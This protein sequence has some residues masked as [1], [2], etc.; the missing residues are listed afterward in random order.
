MP[1]LF[2]VALAFVANFDPNTLPVSLPVVGRAADFSTLVAGLLILVAD[3]DLDIRPVV[4]GVPSVDWILVADFDLNFRPI[5][6]STAGGGG[7]PVDSSIIV[8][9]CAPVIGATSRTTEGGAAFSN[10]FFMD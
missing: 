2:P 5:S 10:A 4:T 9:D 3:F 7:T 8:A 1:S 6:W